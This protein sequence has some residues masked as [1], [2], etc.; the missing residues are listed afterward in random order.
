MKSRE[1]IL[2]A[3]DCCKKQDCKK[4][5]YLWDSRDCVEMMIDDLVSE[6]RKEGK[7]E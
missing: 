7:G 4:C 1:E 6:L 5:P 2:K 3:A